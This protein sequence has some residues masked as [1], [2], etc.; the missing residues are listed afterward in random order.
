MF[1]AFLVLSASTDIMMDL[2]NTLEVENTGLAFQLPYV[3]HENGHVSNVEKV[4][5]MFYFSKRDRP[6]VVG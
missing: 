5:A 1:Y 6:G 3:L 2:V 4:G